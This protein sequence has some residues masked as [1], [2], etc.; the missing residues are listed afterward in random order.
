MEKEKNLLQIGT[1]LC[2]SVSV[3]YCELIS[4]YIEAQLGIRT[5]LIYD[6]RRSSPDVSK[7]D[8]HFMDLGKY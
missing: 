7:G 8:H 5:M 2:P 6:S 4:S 3:E 1:Y